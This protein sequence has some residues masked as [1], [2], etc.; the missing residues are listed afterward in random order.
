MARSEAL[1][2]LL[3]IRD[4]CMFF[5]NCH[6]YIGSACV[7]CA[8]CTHIHIITQSSQVQVSGRGVAVQCIIECIHHVHEMRFN[9]RCCVLGLCL[10]A[11][12]KDH[13]EVAA[14]I[15]RAAAT[16][17]WRQERHVACRHH[18]TISI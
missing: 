6:T 1:G 2:S 8:V 5:S 15:V 18:C 3:Q 14:V 9:T 13:Q 4:D 11:A 12:N 17:A 10:D 7:V 16:P